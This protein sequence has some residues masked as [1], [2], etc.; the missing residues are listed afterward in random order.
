MKS[1]KFLF[2]TLSIVAFTACQPESQ[3]ETTIIE[4]EAPAEEAPTERNLEEEDATE[5]EL[6][7]GEEGGS[8]DVNSEDVDVSINDDE[9]EGN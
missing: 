7:I 4:K 6:D 8:L 3:K 9:G 2:F 1:L 5:V